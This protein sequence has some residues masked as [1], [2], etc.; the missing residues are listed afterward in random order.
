MKFKVLSEREIKDF[1]YN[2]KYVVISIR[3]PHT[4]PVEL[5]DDQ[6]RLATLCIAFSDIDRVIDHPKAILMTKEQAKQILT[7]YSFYKDKVG[8]VV[9]NCEAGISRSSAVAAALT[10]I[11]GGIDSRFFVQYLPNSLVYNLI[12]REY[13]R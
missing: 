13:Y 11:S 1:T 4:R 7:F 12:L 2:E 9:V 10:N 3:S 8:T 6:N 5:L